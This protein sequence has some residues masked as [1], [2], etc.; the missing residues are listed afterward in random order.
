MKTV[1][2]MEI[3]TEL[4]NGWR[5][6]MFTRYSFIQ[7]IAADKMR[8]AREAVERHVDRELTKALGAAG[9]AEFKERHTVNA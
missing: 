5:M 2:G 7:A 3:V 8:L 4:R 6:P 1:R 9:A